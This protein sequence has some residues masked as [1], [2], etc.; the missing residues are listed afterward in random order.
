MLLEVDIPDDMTVDE[1]K[2]KGFRIYMKVV[3]GYRLRT[4]GKWYYVGAA[5]V[6]WTTGSGGSMLFTCKQEAVDARLLLPD[7]VRSPVSII[8][9]TKRVEL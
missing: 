1:L 6:T 9:I 3:V 8:K 2:A 5:D 7:L 4:G